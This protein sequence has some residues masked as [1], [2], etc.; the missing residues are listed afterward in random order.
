MTVFKGCWGD[1]FERTCRDHQVQEEKTIKGMMAYSPEHNPRAR[2]APAPRPDYCV[3]SKNE[4][5]TLLL[6]AKYR[7]LW[8]EA[9]PPEMLY[10]LAIYALSQKPPGRATILY[11]TMDSAAKGF[12]RSDIRTRLRE[13]AGR[14][15]PTSCEPGTAGGTC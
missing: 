2:P 1:S 14:G 4:G 13:S 9:L 7:D 6:D 15:R 3:K 8:A 11:P 5:R 10:Q 12:G